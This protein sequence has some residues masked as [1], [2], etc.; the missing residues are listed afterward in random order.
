MPIVRNIPINLH[1]AKTWWE[2]YKLWRGSLPNELLMEDFYQILP[3]RCNEVLGFHRNINLC[4]FIPKHFLFNGASIPVML[5]FLYTPNSILYL[6]AFL[7]DF[8]YTY[9]G[10]IVFTE[11]MNNFIFVECDRKIS[12][13]IFYE[14]NEEVNKFKTGTYPPYI[15]LR[16]GGGSIWKK[17]REKEEF[18]IDFPQYKDIY[19]KGVRKLKRS[20]YETNLKE[21][22]TTEELH[23]QV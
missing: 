18:L 5:R 23:D 11:E 19:E 21:E 4:C 3:R 1:D 12:D 2:K 15:A 7:H 22:K 9:G 6:G 8:L 14:M 13:I 16:I 10:L 17:A 20:F